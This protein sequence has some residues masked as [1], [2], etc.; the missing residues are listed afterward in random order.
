M[1]EYH[2]TSHFPFEINHA[3]SP[4]LYRSYYLHRSRDSL[5]PVCGIFCNSYGDLCAF[6]VKFIW[7][8]IVF[9]LNN[10]SFPCL[11]TG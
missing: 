5:S 1:I 2:A 3:T 6:C 7:A 4:K 9:V 8:Q 10:F 11:D